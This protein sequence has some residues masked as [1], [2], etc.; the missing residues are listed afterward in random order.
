VD[1]VTETFPG[2][3]LW[4]KFDDDCEKAEAARDLA[5]KEAERERDRVV[6]AP[7]WKVHSRERIDGA[8]KARCERKVKAAE[9]ECK[10]ACER[11]EEELMKALNQ[12]EKARAQKVR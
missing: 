10:A 3:T 1:A 8:A 5:V 9:E 2:V 12:R 4:E 6:K 11:A 7:C